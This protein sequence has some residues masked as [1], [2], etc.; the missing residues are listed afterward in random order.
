[1]T[2]RLL[3]D[4][5]VLTPL[6]TV[7][8]TPPAGKSRPVSQPLVLIGSQE[9]ASPGQEFAGEKARSFYF[10]R[11]FGCYRCGYQPAFSFA[12]LATSAWVA[13]HTPGRDWARRI[14]SS[15]IQIRER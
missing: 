12:H 8:F 4:S 14:N 5:D 2:L 11:E 6:A 3:A 15:M 1:M 10:G 13:N 9:M 7:E